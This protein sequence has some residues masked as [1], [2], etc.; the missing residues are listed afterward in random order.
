M[1][2][3]TIIQPKINQLTK[4]V[5]EQKQLRRVAG[6]A[7]VSTDRDEQFTSYEAQVDY[8]TRYINEHEGWTFVKVYTDEG[9]TGTSTKRRVG[10]NEMVRD[11]LDGKIDLIVTKSVSR[12][13]RNTVDS[14]VTIRKLKE[15]GCECYFEKE[16]IYTF[17]GKGELLLTIMSSLAQEE[18]RSISQ[19]VSWGM[20]E[21]MR[22]G[23]AYVPY[24]IFLGYD[25]GENGEMVINTEQA[26]IVRRIYGM[27][28]Q[29]L[30][31]NRICKILTDEKIPSPGGKD[32]WFITTLN[33]ILTN[34]KYKG[35][36]LRQKTYTK[37]F[38]SKQK[39]K[40]D[41][42]MQQYYITDHH[43]AIIP[44]EI[45][46]RVKREMKRRGT[47]GERRSGGQLFSQKIKCADCG[48]C[49]GPKTWHPHT[50]YTKIIWICNDKYKKTKKK[51]STPHF[52]EDELKAIFVSALNQLI[53]DKKRIISV[54]D[55]IKDTV[56][57][58]QGFK[59]EASSLNSEIK[60]VAGLVAEAQDAGNEGTIDGLLKRYKIAQTRLEEVQ[61]EMEDRL[62]RKSE[63][64][65]FI[66]KLHAQES[67]ITEFDEDLW[68]TLVDYMT[69]YAKNDVRVT[70]K[71]GTEIKA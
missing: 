12:F 5:A 14:L 13:A 20:R 61:K 26:V 43:E 15:V 7:R 21:S 19:N 29:G 60:V 56:F 70:F 68:Y 54:F 45:F 53:T 31:P 38:L 6:Y 35:D 64:D 10:F 62:L 69:V 34:E 16:N 44:P 50:N 4:A 48:S 23:K 17:D 9:L 33:S 42:D 22:Q 49:F 52:Y 51:C 63:V 11:A 30:S 59:A 65:G 28:L 27:Y 32:K 24:S 41:G 66:R 2:N 36:A 57:G 55:A 25:R 1:K 37:D 46:D 47:L 67:F 18:S 8:Y 71:D 39:I 58:V 40:N 3:V